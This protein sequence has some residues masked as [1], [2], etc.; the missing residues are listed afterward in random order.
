M[1][2]KEGV[3][4]ESHP[5]RP[6]VTRRMRYPRLGLSVETRFAHFALYIYD[7]PDYHYVIYGNR[8]R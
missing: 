1:L 4:R 5:S 7:P 2:K 3:Q 6:E 8:G